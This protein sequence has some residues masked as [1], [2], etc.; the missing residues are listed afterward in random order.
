[1]NKVMKTN[2]YFDIG[3]NLTHESF[4]KDLSDVIKN[5]SDWDDYFEKQNKIY[6]NVIKTA[7][8]AGVKLISDWGF[9]DDVPYG[10]WRKDQKAWMINKDYTKKQAYYEVLRALHETQEK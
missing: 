5:D 3:A 10:N 4:N 8:L 6:Y 1:M 9:R 2:T 7:R